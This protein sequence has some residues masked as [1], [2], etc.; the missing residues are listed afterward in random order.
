[1]WKLY[2]GPLIR[3]EGHITE[4]SEGP[5]TQTRLDQKDLFAE[6]LKP[7]NRANPYP[8]YA[9]LR[10]TP[11]ALQRDGTYVVSTYH[12][13]MALLH[14]PRVSADERNRAHYTDKFIY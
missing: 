6:I 8:L 14:D 12:E 1:M 7:A 2:A 13:I 11:V 9:Q 4:E 5:M 10:E 3:T